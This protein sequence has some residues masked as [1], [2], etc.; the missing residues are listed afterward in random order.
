MPS[1]ESVE[2]IK[3]II[4]MVVSGAIA[5]LQTLAF[6]HT[7]DEQAKSGNDELQ[8]IHQDMMIFMIVNYVILAMSLLLLVFFVS[9]KSQYE[10]NVPAL[11]RLGLFIL[12]PLMLA[13]GIYGAYV[14]SKL[15]CLKQD[16]PKLE[17]AYNYSVLCAL[18]GILGFTAVLMVQAYLR[19]VDV[20]PKDDVRDKLFSKRTNQ[21]GM[22]P[23]MM[24]ENMYDPDKM[25]SKLKK[26]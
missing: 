23:P 14:A 25:L 7:K 4:V 5:I 16:N 2:N 21:F 19:V 17:K 24:N 12:S 18:V 10:D 26:K 22:Q 8:K 20:S 13:S 11:V 6:T 1:V 9:Q 15:Q 3:L